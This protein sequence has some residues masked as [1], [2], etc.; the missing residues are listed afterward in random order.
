MSVGFGDTISGPS[1]FAGDAGLA[2]GHLDALDLRPEDRRKI[3]ETNARRVYPRLDQALR[4]A[5]R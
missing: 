5:G 3:Y 4:R 1:V 2:R